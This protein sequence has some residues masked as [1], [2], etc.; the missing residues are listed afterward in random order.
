MQR[1]LPARRSRLRMLP[2]RPP[3]PPVHAQQEVAL[4]QQVQQTK[5][6]RLALSAALAAHQP[7]HSCHRQGT[8]AVGRGAA[9]VLVGALAQSRAGNAP[10]HRWR[11]EG[12]WAGHGVGKSGGTKNSKHL[13]ACWKFRG[14]SRAAHLRM[15]AGSTNSL[16]DTLRSLPSS[17]NLRWPGPPPPLATPVGLPNAPAPMLVSA[18]GAPAAAPPLPAREGGDTVVGQAG[19]P[20]P[21]PALGAGGGPGLRAAG[22]GVM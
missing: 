13:S 10:A 17:S 8:L 22:L 16:P 20:P 14:P 4:P 3:C 7:R 2:P 21:R 15:L 5:R 18:W 11:V 6:C 9:A 19:R 1:A 12:G